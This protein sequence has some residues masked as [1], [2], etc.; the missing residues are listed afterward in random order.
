MFVYFGDFPVSVASIC[1]YFL[2]SLS[3]IFVL[4]RVSFSVQQLLISS[5][6][7][8]FIVITQGSGSEKMLLLVY[9]KR[10]LGLC[11][12]PRVL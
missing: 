3:H 9:V 12:P 2:H 4:F 1:K 11:F 8:I 7:F 10:V 6:L 5:C